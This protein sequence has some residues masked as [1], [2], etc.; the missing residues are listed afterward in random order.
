MQPSHLY[1]VYAVCISTSL[2][3]L[4]F[5]M[6]ELFIRFF[7]LHRA[8]FKQQTV[9]QLQELPPKQQLCSVLKTSS[10]QSFCL[11]FLFKKLFVILY[12]IWIYGQHKTFIS[13]KKSTENASQVKKKLFFSFSTFFWVR[14][15]IEMRAFLKRIR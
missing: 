12:I 5:S 9:K 7:S 4:H 11:F 14:L 8:A 1:S 15:K 2:V 10:A 6:T 13:H 3:V